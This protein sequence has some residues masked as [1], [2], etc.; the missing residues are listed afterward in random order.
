MAYSQQD[1]MDAIDEGNVA[2]VRLILQERD[3]HDN[4]T[5]DINTLQAFGAEW[6]AFHYVITLQSLPT[7]KKYKMLLAIFE[8]RD[9][10]ENPVIN[11][12]KP[13]PSLENLNCLEILFKTA[14]ASRFSQEQVET[15]VDRIIN[16]RKANGARAY[17]FLKE[18]SDILTASILYSDPTLSECYS[19]YE[20]AMAL[21]LLM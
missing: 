21:M 7:D 16:L 3:S 1:L 9:Q 13:C 6:T 19:T 17:N 2:R 12:N 18:K 14:E 5:V 15:L 8:V 10:Y 4:P 20:I 11:F